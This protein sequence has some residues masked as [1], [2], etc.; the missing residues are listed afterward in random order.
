MND[1]FIS[2]IEVVYDFKIVMGF[3]KHDVELLL[4][5]SYST[6]IK[7]LSVQLCFPQ[8]DAH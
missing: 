7:I 4:I 5:P 8:N 6:E 2:D 3:K 1:I